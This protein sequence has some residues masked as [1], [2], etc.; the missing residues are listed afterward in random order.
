MLEAIRAAWNQWFGRVRT[1]RTQAANAC[2]TRLLNNPQ[3]AETVVP[4][5]LRAHPD[6]DDESTH[7]ESRSISAHPVPYD[8][9]LLERARTQWQFGDW[10]SLARLNRETLE[11]HP[12]RAKLALLAAAGRL[13][14]GQAQAARQ[15]TRCA[16]DWGCSKKL[17][18]QILVA[19]VHNNL[20]RAAAVAGQQH[21]A[22]KHFE[23][24][25][26]NGAQGANRQLLEQ[27]RSSQQSIQ[28]GPNPALTRAISKISSGISSSRK[29]KLFIDC[30][31]YDGCSVIKFLIEHDNYDC[32]TF[33]PNPDL[34]HYYNGIPTNLIKKAVS[35]YDGEIELLIDPIDADGS[36]YIKEKK[37]F[38][39]TWCR[40][41]SARK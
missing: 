19:G 7:G 30:G 33:E 39:A 28:L 2:E 37:L 12:D 18:S 29:A 22:L 23:S 32:I 17:I 34:W 9:N 41:T 1:G 38:L 35:T 31:G 13:Q 20:G 36:S 40:I 21:R 26:A 3:I 24:A 27:A 8:E 15:F 5:F 10:E 14:Q 4:E 16:Q 6:G 25:I 11:H